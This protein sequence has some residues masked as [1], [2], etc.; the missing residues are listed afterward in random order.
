MKTKYSILLA[1]LGLALATSATAQTIRISGS[2]AY[3]ASTHDAIRKILNTPTIGDESFAYVGT[4]AATTANL[5]RSSQS[6]FKGQINNAGSV[7]TIKCS[8]NGSAAGV[9]N[10]DNSAST[11]LFLLDATVA[12]VAGNVYVAA[13]NTAQQGNVD[14]ALSDVFQGSTPYNNLLLQDDLVAV[15]PFKWLKNEGASASIT[16]MTPKIVENLYGSRKIALSFFTGSNADALTNV[17][18]FGRDPDSGTRITKSA[19]S[20]IGALA[21]VSQRLFIR[22]FSCSVTNKYI[23]CRLA[24]WLCWHF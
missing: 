14:F 11:A 6:I 21:G 13:G 10:V 7:V 3:R 8:W 20:G 12:S 17:W 24:Y 1:S 2:T 16:N 18:A 4:G 9:E 15:V 5:N 23:N 22:R 19:E